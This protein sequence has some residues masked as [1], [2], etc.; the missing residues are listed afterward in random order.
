MALHARATLD[1]PKRD[2]KTKQSHLV[3]G[4]HRSKNDRF[5]QYRC[6]DRDKAGNYAE[7]PI[8]LQHGT[9]LLADAD[10]GVAYLENKIHTREVYDA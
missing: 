6:L 5:K 3:P 2:F 4:S 10:D 8:L 9:Y 7:I 1:V